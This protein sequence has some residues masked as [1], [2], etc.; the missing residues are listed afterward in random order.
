MKKR[1]IIKTIFVGAISGCVAFITPSAVAQFESGTD[2]L[3]PTEL[4][5]QHSEQ[6]KP[7]IIQITENIYTAVGYD[8]SNASLIVGE[9]GSFIVDTLR[10][11]S[12]A[13]VVLAEFK[14]I[15]DK[16]IEAIIYTHS[17]GD[18]IGGAKVFAQ[19]F[20]P[21][22]YARSNFAP[23][24]RESSVIKARRVRGARQFGRNLS[25][26]E[27]INRGIAP[28]RTPTVGVGEGFL[29]P[30]ETFGD[31]K[32]AVTIAGIQVEMVAAPG[33]TDDQLYVWLPELEVLFSG[34]NFYRAFPN[35]YAIRGTPY[36]DVQQWANSVAQMSQLGADYLVP[37]H[38]RPITGEP[39]IQEALANYSAAIQTVYEQTIAGINR[40]LTPDELVQEVQLPPELASQPY[41]IEFYGAVPWAVRS[42]FTGYLGWFDGNPANLFALPPEAEA[43]RMVELAGGSELFLAE[44]KTS[45]DQEDYQWVLQL[46]DHS[47]RLGGASAVE[48]KKLKIQA[49]RALAE[50]QVNAPARN[51]YLSVANELEAELETE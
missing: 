20:N 46:A 40:G 44:I 51:Y 35:L 8:G 43:Q 4:L 14:K 42:I 6:F 39:E 10:A 34:D 12:A 49:L 24:I 36:R 17:H 16:P 31:E 33:E 32:L 29:P 21:V 30:T 9:T 47:I 50:Q 23:E 48:A 22:I 37:G 15:T 11:T 19:D 1:S 3:T 2:D 25:D 26:D 18:H 27:I 38:T 28:A 5:E 7:E 45:L 13:E 41:L